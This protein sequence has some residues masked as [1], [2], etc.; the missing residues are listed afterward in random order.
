MRSL[1]FILALGAFFLVAAGLSACGSGVPGNAVADM[2]GNPITTTAFKHWMVVAAKGN[3]QG[4][5]APVIV[6]TDPPDFKQCVAQVRKE[7]PGLAQTPTSQIKSDCGQ[8]F[9][10]LS[11]QVMGFLIT[12]YWYQAEAARQHIKVTDA[13]VQQEFN[14]EKASQFHTDA[15]FQAFLSQSGQTQ[16]D[17]LFLV[18]RDLITRKLLARQPTS[19]TSAK[20]QSY[21]QAHLSQF[22]S[23]ESRD[24]RIVLT[25]SSAQADAAKAALAKG[26]SWSAVASQYSV[27]AATK[28]KGGVLTGVTKGQEDQ[29]LE[30]AAFSAPLNKLLGPVQG[31]FGFY[32]FD[33]TK[34][35]AATQQTLAQ[36]TPKIQQLLQSQLQTGAQNAVTKQVR[37]HWLHKTQCRSA[38]AMSDCNGYKP[39]KAAT[40]TAPTTTAPPTSTTTTAPAT[41]TTASATTTTTH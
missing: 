36:A 18:R 20:I 39:P 26:K 30:K 37:D 3:A 6:P 40:S 32:V 22:G 41:T 27:D 23:P 10:S 4:P 16:Q 19:V 33:V 34:I 38:Y 35:T 5:G 1:R 15:A 12:A 29:G 21:Y 8:L 25:H 31:T 13:Q 9:T 17:I 7:I 14:T 28:S 11:S 24:I 2:A